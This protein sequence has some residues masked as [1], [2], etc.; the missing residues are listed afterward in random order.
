MYPG[1]AGG[2]LIFSG[3]WHASKWFMD[4]RR[5]DAWALVPFGIFYFLLGCFVVVSFGGSV[6]QILAFLLVA[7]GGG[8]A[9]LC[10]KDLELRKWVV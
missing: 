2:L 9:F 5:R 8:V 6:T 3:F 7:V 10:R 1:I 4:G